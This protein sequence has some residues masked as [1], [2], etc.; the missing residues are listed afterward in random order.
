MGE[1]AKVTVEVAGATGTIVADAKQFK[2]GS[3]GFYGQG[4][5]QAPD[6]RRFQVSVNVVEIG[7]KGK[8]AT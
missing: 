5:V 7:S 8:A 3:R 1:F 2:T 4:K 6:G